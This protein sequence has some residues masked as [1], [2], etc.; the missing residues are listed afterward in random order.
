MKLH[1]VELTAQDM[2]VIGVALKIVID[3]PPTGAPIDK[4]ADAYARM[5]V[6]TIR[7]ALSEGLGM[8]EFLDAGS[9]GG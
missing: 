9:V 8:S 3:K 1:E 6:E 5:T 4:L 7:I 2:A